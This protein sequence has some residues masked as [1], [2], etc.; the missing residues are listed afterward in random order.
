MTTQATFTVLQNGEVLHTRV[1]QFTKLRKTD[2][3]VHQ[4]NE[5][6]MLKDINKSRKEL[7]EKYNVG[8]DGVKLNVEFKTVGDAK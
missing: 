2:G 4:K 3:T 5:D 7:N 8:N 6:K 1:M